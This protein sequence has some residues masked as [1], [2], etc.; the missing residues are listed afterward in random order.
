M[1]ISPYVE[2]VR[3]LIG[4]QLLLLPS[5]TV[6]PVDDAGRLLLVRHAH[7]GLWGVVGGGVD[8]DE[9]PAGAAVRETREE[10]GYDVEITA[11]VGNVGGPDY[12]V[13][14]PNGDEAAYV[15]AVYAA[16]VIGG[17]ARP[18]GDETTEVAWFDRD[19]LAELELN[20]LARAL[21]RELGWLDG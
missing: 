3:A 9:H 17:V 13:R 21:L 16:R 15:S 18:D 7:G 11:L 14:Y 2:Q 10:T 12:R 19:G 8:V 1:A 4:H 20:P 6:L 5:V